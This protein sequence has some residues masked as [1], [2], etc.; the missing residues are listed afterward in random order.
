MANQNKKNLVEK[1]EKEIERGFNLFK[2][3]KEES[4]K[5][6]AKIESEISEIAFLFEDTNSL[7]KKKEKIDSFMKNIGKKI[8][9]PNLRDKNNKL[10][11]LSNNYNLFNQITKKI[12]AHEKQFIKYKRDMRK[13]KEEIYDKI[14]ELKSLIALNLSNKDYK[15]LL[16]EINEKEHKIGNKSYRLKHLLGHLKSGAFSNTVNNKKININQYQRLN[17]FLNR[18]KKMIEGI[19]SLRD[20]NKEIQKNKKIISKIINKKEIE[21]DKL[22]DKLSKTKQN[23]IKIFGSKLVGVPLPDKILDVLSYLKKQSQFSD[24]LKEKIK[25]L[26]RIYNELLSEI[27]KLKASS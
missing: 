1:F 6:V 12:I 15:K 20:A 21:I 4:E 14:L 19:K 27:Q 25:N 24:K 26:E 22:R 3:Y 18:E 17:Q 9:S 16:K 10:Q 13:N 2:D 11:K 8:T 23:I 7:T 5:F